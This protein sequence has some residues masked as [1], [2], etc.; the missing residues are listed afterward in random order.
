MRSE[1]ICNIG[2][3]LARAQTQMTTAKKDSVNPHFRS[4]YA[5]L[6]SVNEAVIPFLSLNGVAVIQG[7]SMEG[8]ILKVS[9]TFIHGESG[10]WWTEELGLT[11]GKTD[12]Q[13]VGSAITYGR[14]YLLM[15]MACIAPDDDDGNGNETAQ[16]QPIVHRSA[17]AQPVAPRTVVPQPKPQPVIQKTST[18]EAQSKPFASA[19]D[20]L[21]WGLS[22]QC[23][24]HHEHAKNAYEKLKA[25]HK[26]KTAA[27]MFALWIGDVER[28]VKEIEDGGTIEH[29]QTVDNPFNAETVAA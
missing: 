17:P 14:R 1:T 23:F 28:R 22:Q 8:N 16:P 29:E 25:E 15:A 4:S 18:E 13:S 21:Q 6:A 20:A 7:M 24:R 19:E 3:A 12:P 9:T 11:P 5:S 2:K 26:P 10:E 27:N